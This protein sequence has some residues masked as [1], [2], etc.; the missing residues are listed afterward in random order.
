MGGP[1]EIRPVDHEIP[2][3]F[4]QFVSDDGSCVSLAGKGLTEMPD[5]LR[6]LSGLKT[7]DLSDNGITEVPGWL[8]NLGSLKTLNLSNNK[9]TEVPD[10]LER[11]IWQA[12]LHLSGNPL[13]ELPGSRTPSRSQDHW[14]GEWAD[15][16]D[17]KLESLFKPYIS[18]AALVSA[19]ESSDPP[20]AVL[21]LYTWE[22]DRLLALT[23]GVAGLAVTVLTGLIS[24]GVEERRLDQSLPSLP[25]R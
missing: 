18:V 4:R 11:K 13:T 22:R 1:R 16:L 5:W 12:N 8:R 24:A 10:W 23:K 14:P 6:S 15:R 19:A 7:L 3:E 17:Q 20:A 9:L 21:Q 2:S 25:P